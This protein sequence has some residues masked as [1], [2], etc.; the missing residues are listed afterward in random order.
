VITTIILLTPTFEAGQN[1]FQVNGT[2]YIADKAGK[3]AKS[4]LDYV[5]PI[6]SYYISTKSKSPA[7]IYGG[8]WTRLQGRFLLAGNDS[9]DAYKPG[10]KG[11]KVTVSLSTA[12]MPSHTH[13]RGTMDITGEIEL[14]P[15]NT[16]DDNPILGCTGAFSL[17]KEAWS[18]NHDCFQK[19]SV[20]GKQTNHAVFKASNSWSGATSAT[21]SGSAHEN[22]PPFLAVYMWERTG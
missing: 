9:E 3:N 16:G 13:T 21:G 18:G 1:D 20:A 22:M 19:V 8:S 7:E 10:Q 14:R 11:G 15:M 17:T 5:Y 4:L 2:L 6:G 12:E